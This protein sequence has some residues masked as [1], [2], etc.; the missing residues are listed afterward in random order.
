MGILL[1]VLLRGDGREDPG[2]DLTSTVP[3]GSDSDSGFSGSIL[4]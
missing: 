1:L 3:E 2:S 4:V